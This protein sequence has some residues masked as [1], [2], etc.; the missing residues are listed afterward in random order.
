[1]TNNADNG[2]ANSSP[3][4]SLIEELNS[5]QTYKRNKNVIN[6]QEIILNSSSPSN[7][8]SSSSYQSKTGTI[9]NLDDKWI[10]IQKNTFTNWINEQIKTEN[11]KVNDIKHDFADGVKLIKL[12]NALQQPNS[13]VSKRFFRK[14]INQHQ[15]LENMTLALNAITEDGIRL[16][17]IG[18]KIINICQFNSF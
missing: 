18:K 12:V 7:S 14:P 16:V 11:E 15:S 3:S 9:R 2:D 13:K 10:L 17:N 8:S 5:N 6:K 4:L 1:M